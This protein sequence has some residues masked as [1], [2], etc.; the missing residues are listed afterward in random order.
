MSLRIDTRPASR[1]YFE[2]STRS[3]RAAEGYKLVYISTDLR[4]RH[5]GALT[6]F[7][8]QAATIFVRDQDWLFL[9]RGSPRELKYG[10]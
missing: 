4:H 5:G 9:G 1:V 7:Q 2:L 6:E 3:S 10:Y 8:P